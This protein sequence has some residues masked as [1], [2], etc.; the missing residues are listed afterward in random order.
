MTGKKKGCLFTLLVLVVVITIGIFVGLSYVPGGLKSLSFR[1]VTRGEVRYTVPDEMWR[2]EVAKMFPLTQNVVDVVKLHM[3]NP[4]WL[5][6]PDPTWLRLRL[7]LD[8]QVTFSR[9]EH[10]PGHAE[11]RTQLRLDPVKRAVV[12]SKAELVDFKLTGD[13]AAVAMQLQKTLAD[14]LATEAEGY[15][16]F[17]LPKKGPWL[18]RTGAG[19]V[20]DVVVEGGK[21]TVVTGW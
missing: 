9:V 6:D 4:R 18:E 10:Y 13:A 21:V 12:L 14:A 8:A 19:F 16:V 11:M 15:P 20:R 7:D 17:D 3:S 5:I 1:S 2:G